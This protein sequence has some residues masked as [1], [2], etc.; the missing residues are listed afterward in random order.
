MTPGGRSYYFDLIS[1]KA[2]GVFADV[3]RAAL[4]ILSLGYLAGVSIRNARYRVFRGAARKATRPVISVGNITTGGTGKT[5][6]TAW[7][8]Q[9]LGNQ[10]R[11]VGI[12]TRGY[13]GRPVRFSDESR[14]D[15]ASQWRIESDEA[16]LLTRLCPKAIVVIDPDRVA[17]AERAASRGAEVLVL[18]DGFQH[19]RLAR[20]L[21]IVLID[22]TAAFGFGYALPRG[23]LRESLRG[24]RRAGLIILTR[25]DLVS[26]EKR[27]RLVEAIQRM[28][29]GK[30][31]IVARHHIPGFADV[32]GRPVGE[33]DARAMQAVLF[34][35]LGHFDP[36]RES[37]ERLGA[38]VV[39]AYQYPDHHDYSDEE[40]S[41]LTEVCTQLDA[42][43]LITTEKDAVK[44]VGRW[45]DGPVPLLTARLAIEFDAA[46]EAILVR[47]LDEAASGRR[48][49]NG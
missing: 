9:R 31:L 1:G 32:K 27:A 6:M 47:A 40:I 16:A 3:M 30:P 39:A 35:G 12:L 26:G 28:S 49:A 7:I 10:D 43:A 48:G 45:P 23:L 2:R 15:A 36:F 41:Q 19:R 38:T 14:E 21:D 33:V 24:L 11:I 8:A 37:I 25:S 29:G 42:N 5:P 18:D 17:G 4:W 20:D 46:D 44:L 13:R 22:A 34:A